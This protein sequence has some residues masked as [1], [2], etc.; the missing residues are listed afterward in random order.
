M[1]AIY[2]NEGAKLADLVKYVK[3]KGW[4]NGDPTIYGSKG[5]KGIFENLISL[6][7]ARKEGNNTDVDVVAEDDANRYIVQAKNSIVVKRNQLA[8]YAERISK[9]FDKVE[10]IYEVQDKNTRKLLFVVDVN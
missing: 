1:L 2:N 9:Q 5:R 6:G 4:I 8:D 7:L 3:A 10:K